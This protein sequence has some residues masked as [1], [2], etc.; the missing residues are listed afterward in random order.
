M[1]EFEDIKKL[2]FSLIG[3]ECQ[4]KGTFVFQGHTKIAG[5]LEGDITILGDSVLSIEINGSI[6]GS[7]KCQDLE[8][9]GSFDGDI[10]SSGKVTLFPPAVVSGTLKSKNIEVY[11]GAILNLDSFTDNNVS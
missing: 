6:R 11:S 2:E 4:F 10:D 9:S 7:I 8:V 5:T 3:A 1:N